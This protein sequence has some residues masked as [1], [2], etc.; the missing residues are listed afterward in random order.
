MRSIR[1]IEPITVSVAQAMDLLSIGKTQL[2][3]LLN[4]KAILSFKQGK[5]RLI[6]YSS[7]REWAEKHFE[8]LKPSAAV[9]ALFRKS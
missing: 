7:M 5:R 9:D 3:E 2:Y 8:S 4:T 6:M 1:N